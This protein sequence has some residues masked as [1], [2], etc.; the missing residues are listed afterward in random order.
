MNLMERLN[1]IN[2]ETEDLT[3]KSSYLRSDAYYSSKQLIKSDKFPNMEFINRIEHWQIFAPVTDESVAECIYSRYGALDTV[4]DDF[5][6]LAK[7]KVFVFYMNVLHNDNADFHINRINEIEFEN[8]TNS[9]YMS[10]LPSLEIC[11]TTNS[12]D[13]TELHNEF[14]ASN[15]YVIEEYNDSFFRVAI[16]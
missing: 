7:D 2:K 1:K 16:K 5:M 3:D 13:M 14:I 4:F 8:T 12:K 15:K 11:R 6:D 10:F 9:V